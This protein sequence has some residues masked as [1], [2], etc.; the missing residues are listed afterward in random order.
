MGMAERAADYPSRRL[1]GVGFDETS[2]TPAVAGVRIMLV[3][4]SG[5]VF[6]QVVAESG[7]FSFATSRK[8]LRMS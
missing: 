6:N 8:L 3:E 4:V 5:G 2:Q 1:H 7:G